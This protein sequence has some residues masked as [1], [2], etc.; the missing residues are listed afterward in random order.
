[1][2][3]KGK[4]TYL[5]YSVQYILKRKGP[6]KEVI[7]EY[8]GDILNNYNKTLKERIVIVVILISSS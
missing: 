2:V 6:E 8:V 7:P 1:M 3:G 4:E 5:L